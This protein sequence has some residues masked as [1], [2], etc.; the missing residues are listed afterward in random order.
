MSMTSRAARVAA[1]LQDLAGPE[2]RG[3]GARAGVRRRELPCGA[4][5]PV[6]FA[7]T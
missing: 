2:H 6:P 3:A 1:E 4:N 7:S 5:E